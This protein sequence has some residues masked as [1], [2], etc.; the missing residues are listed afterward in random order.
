MYNALD[1]YIDSLFCRRDAH[2]RQEQYVSLF[3][4]TKLARI[5]CE[6]KHEYLKFCSSNQ[7]ENS[8]LCTVKP[9]LRG[10]LWDKEKISCAYN[11][12]NDVGTIDT[13]MTYV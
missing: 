3:F 5:L 12:C 7:S 4:Q 13:V 6:Y 2:Y 1:F 8:L 9:V 11:T 10:H